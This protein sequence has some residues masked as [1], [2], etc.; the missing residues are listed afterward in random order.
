MGVIDFINLI[1]W[2]F[3]GMKNPW[4]VG[5]LKCVLV[6]EP[7]ALFALF[8]CNKRI[9]SG[10]EEKFP[11]LRTGIHSFAMMGAEEGDKFCGVWKGNL[12]KKI[13]WKQFRACYP[14]RVEGYFALQRTTSLNTVSEVVNGTVTLLIA[15]K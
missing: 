12:I 10:L 7:T 3:N 2:Y 14:I 1:T 8:C 4:F 15:E 6:L 11:C 9:A 5:V 13:E